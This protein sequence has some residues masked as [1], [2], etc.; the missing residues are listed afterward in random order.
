MGWL[1]D[2]HRRSRGLDM[3]HLQPDSALQRIPRAA[4]EM[5]RHGRAARRPAPTGGLP[6]HSGGVGSGLS[7]CAGLAVAADNPRARAP[8]RAIRK[9]RG[10]SDVPRPARAKHEAPNPGGYFSKSVQA[11]RGA[12]VGDLQ[13]PDARLENASPQDQDAPSSWSIWETSQPPRW[14]STMPTRR[15][16]ISLTPSSRVVRQGCR[17]ALRRHRLS[18][19]R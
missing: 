1:M 7:G 13:L 10:P 15:A 8:P 3:R 4:P 17:Q 14:T 2:L 9:R 19:G 18:A 11:L 5:G 12:L 6:A 16:R